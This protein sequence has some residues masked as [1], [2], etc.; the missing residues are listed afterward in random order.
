M[1]GFAGKVAVVTGAGS[2]IGQALAIELGRSG[3]KLA[4]SD[5]DTEGLAVDRGAADGH[6]CAGE[7][8]P[9]RRHRA[10]GVRAVR[11]RGQRALRQGQPDLQQRGH[12]L[13]RR[14]RGQPVQGHRTGDGR[15]LLGRGQ[16]HQG[17]PAAPDRL[18][19]RPRRQRLQRLRAVRGA[20]PGRLQRGQVRGA[21]VHRGAAP[22]DD[23]G[24]PP[25]QGDDA[26]IPAASRPRSPATADRGRGSGPGRSWR[27]RS[28]RGWPAPPPEKAAR[29]ILDGV[30][31]NKARVLVGTDA[32]VLDLIVRVTGSGYQRVVAAV[33]S[34]QGPSLQ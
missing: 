10:R 30:R 29:I 4:I 17:L 31:K 14:R 9:A 27:S 23:R 5:V 7:G 1:K 34:R 18:R 11:R 8:R 28:T 15:R 13:H 32:K 16:R 22:G 26:C 20:R 6:R 2:G 21:R 19:R 25:G 12:R 33:T 24:R 3:A